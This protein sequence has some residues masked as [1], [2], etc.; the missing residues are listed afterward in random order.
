MDVFS[1]SF[2]TV[3]LA[4]QYIDKYLHCGS[5]NVILDKFQLLGAAALH[6]ASKCEDVA[7]IGEYKH[8]MGAD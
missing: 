6:L 5:N 2:R 8:N 1:V 3:Y 4:V 7:Y